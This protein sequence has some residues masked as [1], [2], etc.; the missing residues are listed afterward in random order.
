METYYL[1]FVILVG[2]AVILKWIEYKL[3]RNDNVS[4]A[5]QLS[6]QLESVP[7]T[8]NDTDETEIELIKESMLSAT[9]H[10]N[11]YHV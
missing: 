11:D 10:E 9:K 3:T 2:F 6:T 8:S 7:L 5:T 4:K 1:W